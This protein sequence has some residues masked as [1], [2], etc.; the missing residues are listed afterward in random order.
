MAEDKT[1]SGFGVDVRQVKALPRTL[2]DVMWDDGQI[3]R[4]QDVSDE[5]FGRYLANAA[6][7][8]DEFT[9]AAFREAA[10]RLIERKEP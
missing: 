8:Q 1:C 10:R 5:T 3:K 7:G 4:W 2:L 6:P 9:T